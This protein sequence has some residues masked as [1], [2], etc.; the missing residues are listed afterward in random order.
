VATA[1]SH[2][3]SKELQGDVLQE[4]MAIPTNLEIVSAKCTELIIKVRNSNLTFVAYSRYVQQI[5]FMNL[6]HEPITFSLDRIDINLAEPETIKPM[7]NILQR[8]VIE[9]EMSVP[10]PPFV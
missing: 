4:L 7:P 5:P 10:S 8:Y 3:V 6:K 9:F 1:L 2:D